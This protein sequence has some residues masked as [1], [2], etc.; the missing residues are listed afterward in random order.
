MIPIWH[1]YLLQCERKGSWTQVDMTLN[2][3]KVQY[4]IQ[5]MQNHCSYLTQLHEYTSNGK[6]NDKSF[7]NF[8]IY[9]AHRTKKKHRKGKKQDTKNTVNIFE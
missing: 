6:S 1:F 7:Q 3:S 8:I 9:A 5:I 2:N 4:K